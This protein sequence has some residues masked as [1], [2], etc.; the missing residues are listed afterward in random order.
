MAS[1]PRAL[2]LFC[3]AG[4][5][6]RGLQ[7][8]GFRVTG[9]DIRRQP[10]Y[11]GDEFI[12]ADALAVSLEGYDFIW[13][14]PPCQ[15]Y[16]T[17]VLAS[18]RDR[19]PDL[20]GAV[21]DILAAHGAPFLIENVPGAECWLRNPVMLCGSMFGLR[22]RRHR[23][24]ELHGFGLR[25]LIPPCRHPYNAVTVWMTGHFPSGPSWE[26]KWKRAGVQRH[27][28]EERVEAAG[29]EWMRGEVTMA[30]PPV[31]AAFLASQFLGRRSRWSVP[32]GF[33]PI[34]SARLF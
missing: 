17:A 26:R 11:C 6:T 30:I 22:V 29:V 34:P 33:P 12:Q 31:Y 24:F 23:L 19:H 25:N 16:S 4:G 10:R 28:L 7:M 27:T 8:A 3:C 18:R 32:T 5:A 9:V 15:H 21:R 2:D 1:K 13:A 14:S 20:I